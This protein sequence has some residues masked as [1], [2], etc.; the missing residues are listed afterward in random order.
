MHERKPDYALPTTCGGGRGRAR[1]HSC[2]YLD[3]PPSS[4]GQA[5]GLK[6][7]TSTAGLPA[8]AERPAVPLMML[9]MTG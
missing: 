8:Q 6:P 3:G 5:K 2:P 7:G 9:M 4:G 1:K